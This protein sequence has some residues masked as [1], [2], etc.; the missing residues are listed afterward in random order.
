MGSQSRQQANR[1]RKIIYLIDIF[2]HSLCG[3]LNLEF[4]IFHFYV[5]KGLSLNQIA[6]KLEIS[7][8]LVRK[9][10]RRAGVPILSKRRQLDLTGQTP[11]GWKKE[12]GRLVPHVAEQKVI[13]RFATARAE[14]ISLHS[15][16]RILNEEAVP[17]KNGGRWHARSVSQIL[18][19]NE[20][21][22]LE[23]K[24]LFSNGVP[25]SI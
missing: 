19:S 5:K 13:N 16:A 2:G 11:Y 15:I 3:E 14:G 22:M 9:I 8:D 6:Q 20:R 17:T 21:F 18:E 12:M 4:R 7:R 25:K 10:L 24:K 1:T 23:Y